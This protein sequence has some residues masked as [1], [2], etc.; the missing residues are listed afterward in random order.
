[1]NLLIWEG[2]FIS[3]NFSFSDL[4]PA[5]SCLQTSPWCLLSLVFTPVMEGG[6]PFHPPNPDSAASVGSG[7]AALDLRASE[8]VPS[9]RKQLLI[10]S[11]HSLYLPVSV[12]SLYNSIVTL[13][14]FFFL[15]PRE[16]CDLRVSEDSI[17]TQLSLPCLV[18]VFRF[19]G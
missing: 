5:S 18:K 1:M 19:Q 6:L 15:I 2:S 3:F 17:R 9:F 12:L 7:H 14:L 11:H 8:A 4:T 13:R 10:P 16:A